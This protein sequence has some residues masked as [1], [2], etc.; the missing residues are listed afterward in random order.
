MEIELGLRGIPFIP[1]ENLAT[2]YKDQQLK[3]RYEPDLLVFMQIVVELKS[4]RELALEHEAQL[5]NYMRLTRK[6]IGYLI[7]FGPISKVEWK[8]MVISEFL[9]SPT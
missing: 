9:S 6:P 1:K 4:T 5:M 8:R 2:F 7:N 3:K